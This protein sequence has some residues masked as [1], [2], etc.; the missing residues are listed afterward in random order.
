MFDVKNLQ[1]Y[2]GFHSKAATK[3]KTSSP[4]LPP[5]PTD[6]GGMQK[7]K[8]SWNFYT[9]HTRFCTFCVDLYARSVL[10]DKTSASELSRKFI[11][12]ALLVGICLSQMCE[13]ILH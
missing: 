3:K 4:S 6:N 13:N 12:S 8:L 2:V 9:L 11:K 5:F 1:I 7:W 10:I